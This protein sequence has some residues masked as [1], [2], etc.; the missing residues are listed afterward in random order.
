LHLSSSSLSFTHYPTHSARNRNSKSL[1]YDGI[2][3]LKLGN[4]EG[5]R[6]VKPATRTRQQN[7]HSSSPIMENWLPLPSLAYRLSLSA[8]WADY[9]HRLR[10]KTKVKTGGYSFSKACTGIIGC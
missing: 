10:A 4:R 2:W 3:I 1:T 8:F 7:F 6:H 9:S 5:S